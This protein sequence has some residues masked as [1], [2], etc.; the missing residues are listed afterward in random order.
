M[1]S[2]VKSFTL[3]ELL[4]VVAIIGILAAVGVPIF[5]NFI[6]TSK[7]VAVSENFH[8]VA[9]NSKLLLMRCD[10]NGS[11]TVKANTASPR[12]SNQTFICMNQNTNSISHILRDHYHFSGF[13]NPLTGYSATWWFGTPKGASLK[14]KDG[15]IFFDGKPTNKCVI[16]ITST[17]IN[18]E[19]SK[20]ETFERSID[21][22]GKVSQC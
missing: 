18:P 14:D 8:R 21:M 1:L 4:V 17:V 3:I 11:I 9:N 5:N 15:Y 2:K 19:T 12:G 7:Y 16:K 22:R 20:K 6:S 13:I 10:I